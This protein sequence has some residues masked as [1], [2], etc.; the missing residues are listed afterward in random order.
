MHGV[1]P[2]PARL[3]RPPETFSAAGA[4]A[5]TAYSHRPAFGMSLTTAADCGVTTA[6]L[7][8]LHVDDA[9]YDAAAEADAS[10]SSSSVSIA[11]ISLEAAP[12]SS[13]WTDPPAATGAQPH[14]PAV[15]VATSGGTPKAAQSPRAPGATFAAPEA[16]NTRAN[17]AAT[18]PR[19]FVSIGAHRDRTRSAPASSVAD[20]LPAV[21]A[22]FD[23]PSGLRGASERRY[24]QVVDLRPEDVQDVPQLVSAEGADSGDGRGGSVVTVVGSAA[25]CPSARRTRGQSATSNGSYAS[26]GEDDGDGDDGGVRPSRVDGAWSGRSADEVV[27]SAREAEAGARLSSMRTIM[28]QLERQADALEIELGRAATAADAIEVG[29]SAHQL[30]AY[31]GMAQHFEARVA[32]AE[33]S[34]AIA[35]QRATEIGGQLARARGARPGLPTPPPPSASPG[36]PSRPP[37]VPAP[38]PPAASA[39]PTHAPDASTPLCEGAHTAAT[40]GPHQAT[41]AA[42]PPSPRGV[43]A[44]AA[45][46]QGARGV[47]RGRSGPR[48]GGRA[49]GRAAG[50]SGGRP[51]S[52]PA[53]GSSSSSGRA[54]GGTA[55][56]GAAPADRLW[57][58]RAGGPGGSERVAPVSLTGGAA[59]PAPGGAAHPAPGG[60]AHPAPGGAA[61][62]APGGATSLARSRGGR[63]VGM[64]RGRGG[65]G[66]SGT[67]GASVAA[68][69]SACVAA[70]VDSTAGSE[71]PRARQESSG[72]AA[73]AARPPWDASAGSGSTPAT[74]VDGRAAVTPTARLTRLP[75]A[76]GA[77]ALTAREAQNG[78]RRGRLLTASEQ[79][80]ASAER[81]RQQHLSAR[82]AQAEATLQQLLTHEGTA[83]AP[84]TVADAQTAAADAPLVPVALPPR[85]PPATRTG[86]GGRA[87]LP[88]SVQGT[89]ARAQVLAAAARTQAAGSE[90]SQADERSMRSPN[91]HSPTRESQVDPSHVASGGAV[92]SGGSAADGGGTDGN[93]LGLGVAAAAAAAAAGASA[94]GGT[95]SGPGGGED[96]GGGGGSDGSQSG[97][98]PFGHRGAASGDRSS[99][100]AQAG[101]EGSAGRRRE[102][103]AL[104]EAEGRLLG[105]ML[106]A[107]E[108]RCS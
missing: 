7:R 102:M 33:E 14:G 81:Q 28:A 11:S 105:A 40:A 15:A 108:P 59:H 10:G 83:R 68:C 4:V 63:A 35:R 29:Y 8:P 92:A 44:A 75:A 98:E 46:P 53:F 3:W 16:Y 37:M 47:G 27:D 77:R 24:L 48:A 51:G 17:P 9:G 6:L 100:G 95:C 45:A 21:R 84:V 43:A 42:A 71:R 78:L 52:T 85:D 57:P 12:Q 55:E 80:R 76:G 73:D 18:S 49:P 19:A 13:E 25:Q 106:T 41:S 34:G 69:V 66:R 39:H 86:S 74:G 61:H 93:S 50:R 31:A 30:G 58:D 91:A 65:G 101:Q 97:G 26:A 32:A 104:R 60:A 79:L 94:C 2:P 88:A 54:P 1:E 70:R 107:P 87:P 72:G 56:G 22:C 103:A 62:P 90:A 99:H 38:T 96:G 89:A 64:G 36:A 23:V 5:A 67:R 20:V 82:M